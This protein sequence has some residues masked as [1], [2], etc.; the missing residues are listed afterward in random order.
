MPK[1]PEGGKIVM[2]KASDLG[3]VLSADRLP[4][5]TNEFKKY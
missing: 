1:Y 4:W 2:V 5:L 3:N